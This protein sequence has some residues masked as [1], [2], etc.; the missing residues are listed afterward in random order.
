MRDSG[1][2][3]ALANCRNCRQVQEALHS[4]SEMVQ[5]HALSLLYEIKQHDRLAISKMARKRRFYLI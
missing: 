2:S 4:P 5:F 1:L 3:T